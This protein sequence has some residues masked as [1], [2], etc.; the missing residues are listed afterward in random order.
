MP[1]GAKPGERRG[2]RAVGTK[3]RAT[4]ERAIIAERIT[5]EAEMAGRKLGKE[6]LEEFMVL[7]AGLAA[8][9]QPQATDREAIKVWAGTS[10][11][12]MFEKYA[13]LSCACAEKLA[14]FQSP[15]MGRV[16]TVAP[17]PPPRQVQKRFSISVFEHGARVVPVSQQQITAA[18][19]A[20]TSKH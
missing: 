20:S 10:S 7:F 13:K 17:P 16:Q 19:P 14:E 2:G 18:P 11:E 12:P 6:Q 1:R 4:I 15:K 3:N 8:S 9:F 5:N